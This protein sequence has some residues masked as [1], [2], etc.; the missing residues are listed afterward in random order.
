MKN[1]VFWNMAPCRSF[2]DRRFGRTYSL[3]FLGRKIRVR[4]TSVSSLLQSP[5]GFFYPENE[6]DTFFRNVGSHKIYMAPHPRRGHS[7]VIIYLKKH[8]ASD[9]DAFTDL[10]QSGE[11]GRF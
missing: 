7:F 10:S 3:H 4:G 5:H 9:T 1:A 11:F 2:V 8:I 6:C